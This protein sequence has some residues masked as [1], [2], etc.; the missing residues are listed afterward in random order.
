[1]LIYLL[2]A[3]CCLAILWAFYKLFLESEK[4]HHSKRAYLLGSV[5]FSALVPAIT[6]TTYVEVSPTDIAI[7]STSWNETLV[8]EDGIP[9]LPLLSWSLYV[10]GFSFFGFRFFR[11]LYQIRQKIRGNLYQYRNGNHF[12]LLSETVVPHTF[13]KYIFIAK[14]DFNKDRVPESVILHE[15][16]HIQQKHT[17]DILFIEVMCWLFWFNPI[18]FLVKR[19]IR[20]NHE[21]LAD[22][23]VLEK[24]YSTPSYQKT[25]L[26]Y[27]ESHTNLALSHSIHFKPLKKR[28]ALMKKQKST[29]NNLF[30][31]VLIIPLI[32][33]LIVAFSTKT[34]AQIQKSTSKEQKEVPAIVKEYNKLAKAYNAP[35]DKPRVFK[36]SDM[37]SLWKLYN[38]MTDEQ[39]KNAEPFPN[40]PPPPPPAPPQV[41]EVEEIQQDPPKPVKP[42]VIKAEN[43]P[44]DATS[45]SPSHEL[46]MKEKRAIERQI[47]S[48]TVQGR[49]VKE[50]AQALEEQKVVLGQ[51]LEQVQDQRKALEKAKYLAKVEKNSAKLAVPDGRMHNFPTQIKATKIEYYLDGESVTQEEFDGITGNNGGPLY[52]KVDESDEETTYIYIS[53]EPTDK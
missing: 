5:V 41:I 46:L 47:A 26:K 7:A 38:Q 14:D 24:G 3:S 21:F 8:A 35:T 4:M 37:E 36:R 52:I 43:I 40:I 6:F 13:L 30:K 15:K 44:Q 20:L 23:A 10:L 1:M 31:G 28:F 19:E 39:K 48:K 50:Q 45:A 53:T 51:Q 12:V 25:L 22:E 34:V 2:K 33:F 17:Y 11:N 18:L 27:G 42:Q 16:V 9:L 49:L 29:T 32:G